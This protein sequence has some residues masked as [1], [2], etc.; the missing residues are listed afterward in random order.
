MAVT[1]AKEVFETEL[2]NRFKAKPDIVAKINSTYKFVLDGDA[3]GTWIV[4]LTDGGKITAGEGTAACTITMK[5]ADFVDMI[6]GK[7]NAQMAFM[8]GKLKVAG[9]MGLALKLQ[10]L[11]G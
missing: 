11:F 6:N 2:P 5:S 9:D 7:L 3:G 4:D 10:S 8:S 1:T